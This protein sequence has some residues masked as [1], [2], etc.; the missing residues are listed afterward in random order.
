MHIEN[1]A[2]FCLLRPSLCTRLLLAV[3]PSVFYVKD[4]TLDAVFQAIVEDLIPLQADGFPVTC[5]ILVEAS[6]LLASWD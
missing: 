2:I 3:V 4:K 5:L 1:G 6:L